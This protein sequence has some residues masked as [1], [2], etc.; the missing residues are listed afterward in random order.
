MKPAGSA[1]RPGRPSTG[2]SGPALPTGGAAPRARASCVHRCSRTRS[3]RSARVSPPPCERHLLTHVFQDCAR[4]GTR[5]GPSLCPDTCVRRVHTSAHRR[6]QRARPTEQGVWALQGPQPHP[7][8]QAPTQ[9]S[10]EAVVPAHQ[11]GAQVTNRLNVGQE[12]TVTVTPSP[13]LQS[14]EMLPHTSLRR[15]FYTQLLKRQALHT[16]SHLPPCTAWQVRCLTSFEDTRII[17]LSQSSAA[18]ACVSVFP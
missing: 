11:L 17:D 16:N 6:S 2:S 3:V 15:E 14:L 10:S 1:A 9:N 12:P 4:T 13:H 7:P 8:S 18:C 5:G